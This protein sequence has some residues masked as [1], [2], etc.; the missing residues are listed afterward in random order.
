MNKPLFDDEQLKK[1]A[2]A[3]AMMVPT[4]TQAEVLLRRRVMVLVYDT[5]LYVRDGYENR[6]IEQQSAYEEE[7]DGYRP[8]RAEA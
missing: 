3:I 6:L 1:E 7:L 5:L 8:R 4:G 2:N